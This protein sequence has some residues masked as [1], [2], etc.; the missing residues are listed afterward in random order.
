VRLV[1]LRRDEIPTLRKKRETMDGENDM[2]RSSDVIFITVFYLRKIPPNRGCAGRG[3]YEGQRSR[4]IA[5]RDSWMERRAKKR[6]SDRGRM[7]I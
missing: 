4:R 6:M 5:R 2:L 1:L 3:R 7:H